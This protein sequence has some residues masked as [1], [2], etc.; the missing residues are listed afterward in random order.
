[1]RDRAL[2]RRTQRYIACDCQ[3]AGEYRKLRFQSYERHDVKHLTRRTLIK[4]ASAGAALAAIGSTRAA[5]ARQNNGAE[6]SIGS[7]NF[8]ESLI[9]GE[10]V[11]LLLEQNGFS[12]NRHLNLGGTVVA[13]ESLVNGD[14]DAYV[15]YT[16]TGLMAILGHDLPAIDEGKDQ[17]LPQMVYD[18]VASEYPEEFDLVWLEPWGFNNTNALIMT[19]ESAEEL[20]VTKTSDLKPLAGEMTLGSDQEFRVRPDGLPQF[21]K[22]YD[23]SFDEVISGDIGLMYPALANGEVDVIQGYSTDGRIQSLDLVLLEDDLGFFPPYFAAPVVRRQLL[24]E[25]PE[26]ETIL[27]Q[28]SGKIDDTT[29]AG[30][31]ARVDVDD[32]EPIEAAREFLEAEDLYDA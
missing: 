8:T 18:I 11:G 1:M 12:V 16:G 29:M 32:L 10:M 4:G 21:E 19:R 2:A 23:F 26:I 7:K 20:G 22:T 25:N 28:L 15:E 31:N 14:I 6:V 13:H 9:V 3:Y 17:S 24:E 27:N 5:V 30:I